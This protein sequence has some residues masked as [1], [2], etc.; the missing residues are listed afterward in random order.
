[1]S[2]IHRPHLG[3]AILAYPFVV[4]NQITKTSREILEKVDADDIRDLGDPVRERPTAAARRSAGT[5]PRHGRSGQT[6]RDDVLPE[7][8]KASS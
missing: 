6:G 7:K 4:T 5:R 3:V 2:Y 1:M 8:W